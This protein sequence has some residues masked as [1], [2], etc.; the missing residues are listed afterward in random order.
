MEFV[1]HVPDGKPNTILRQFKDFR[2]IAST[3]DFGKIFENFLIKFIHGVISD[4]LSKTQYGGKK[5]VGME[6]VLVSMIDT[7]RKYQEDPKDLPIAMN[8]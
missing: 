8:S 5:G 7:I 4:K 3:S 6:H 1:T 2:K